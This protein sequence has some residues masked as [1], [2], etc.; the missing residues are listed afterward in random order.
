V[1]HPPVELVERL[2]P[3]P[4]HDNATATPS[5]PPHSSRSFYASGAVYTMQ[6]GNAPGVPGGIL[7]AADPSQRPPP[8]SPPPH[9][10]R[11]W[12]LPAPGTSLYAP[13]LGGE[14]EVSNCP[15]HPCDVT[16]H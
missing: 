2:N 10:R 14:Y 16:F 1:L 4:D 9:Q 12:V 5:S 13:I 8:S 11:Q 3:S 15:A 7:T 6:D